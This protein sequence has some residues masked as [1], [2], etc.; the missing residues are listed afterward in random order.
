M[1]TNYLLLYFFYGISNFFYG[2][3]IMIHHRIH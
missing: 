2:V 3:K 1:I